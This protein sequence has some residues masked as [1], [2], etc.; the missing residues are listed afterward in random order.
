MSVFQNKLQNR[1]QE[2]GKSSEK[3][4][5]GT[6]DLP[7]STDSN[8]KSS[9]N[10]E[11]SLDQDE[12]KNNTPSVS[13][14][15]LYLE[16]IDRTRLDFDFEKL[17]SVSLSNNN[18]YAC[19]TCGKYFQGRGKSSHAYF[20]SIDQ[21]HHVYINLLSYKFYILPE[22]YEV[23]SPTLDDI[24]Y[25]ADPV[26]TKK[27][28]S[29]LDKISQVSYDLSRTPYHPGFV[30][31]NNIKRNDYANVILQ[32]ISHTPPLR[33]FL[34][35]ENL[36]GKDE[37]VKRL[38]LIVRKIWNP[39][40]FKAHVS[41]HELL[42][43]V[44]VLSNK[45]FIPTIQ[46]DPFDFMVWLF[47]KLHLS[48]GGSKTK[49]GSSI[50]QLVFQGKLQVQTQKIT[51][52]SVPGDRLRFEADQDV[53][54]QVVPFMVLALE[55]PL[56]PLFKGTID[57]NAI[58]QVHLTTLL[59]RYNGVQTQ[60]LSGHRKRYKLKSLPP[61]LTFHFKRF[62]KAQLSDIEEKNQTVV[63]F[64]P[65][66]LDMSP[67][68]ERSPEETDPILYD[69]IAN[70]VLD[71]NTTSQGTEQNNWA[72]QIKDKATGKWLEI[73]DLTIKEVRPE[74]LFLSETYIQ[75]WEKRK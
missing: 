1:T 45:R 44:T 37:L 74:L 52:H 21:D 72:V 30:G 25:V 9:S 60:E 70:V 69:L 15:T 4:S 31:I 18:V 73:Q 55:L 11:I 16:T 20:H 66:G 58:P 56:A 65:E 68:I 62:V 53:Q 42:Q 29:S 3:I 48:L 61:Y 13:S 8:N 35:L 27:E 10:D 28:V 19:L 36:S 32:I 33:N 7:V 12:S 57:K 17:C 22:G 67:Y 43:Y 63:S 39:R 14:D 6:P 24:K 64:T 5:E 75:V 46:N 47:N 34:M 49:P 50:V 23:K 2:A 40:A 54:S 38:S 41:P 59:G 71:V 26:Y 51:A